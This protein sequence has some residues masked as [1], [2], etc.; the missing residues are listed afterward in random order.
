MTILILV[1]VLIAL[2]GILILCGNGMGI[3]SVP[4]MVKL[5]GFV[6]ALIVALVVILQAAG[7][8]IA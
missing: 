3:G 6:F 8:N 5:A 4:A 7:V 2:L 1:I